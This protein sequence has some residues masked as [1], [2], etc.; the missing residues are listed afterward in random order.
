MEA[1]A[2]A[3]PRRRRPTTWP[4]SSAPSTRRTGRRSPTSTSRRPSRSSRSSSGTRATSEGTPDPE[5]RRAVPADAALGAGAVLVQGP[6]GR[7]PDDQRPGRDGRAEAGVPPGAQDRGAASSRP[8]AGTSGSASDGPQAAVLHALPRRQLD[9]DGRAVGVLEAQGRPG[10]RVRRRAGHLRRAHHGRGRAAR[11][12]CTTG[13]RWCCR[14]RRGRRG[15]TRTRRRTTRPSPRCSRLRRPELVAQPGAA[16]GVAAGQQRAQQRPRAPRARCRP[17]QVAEPLQLD[18]LAGRT[19]SDA[20]GTRSSPNPSSGTSTPR[21]GP[22]GSPCTRPRDAVAV[23]LLGHGAGGGVRRARPAR[24]PTTAALAA[25][26]HV[27]QVEQP[28]R[29]AGRRAPAPA[30]QLDAAWLAV[31]AAVRAAAARATGAR[32]RPQLGRPGGLPDG[33]GR[34]CRR[35]AVPG[36]PGAPAGPAGEGPPGRAGRADGPGA[37]RPGRARPLRSPAART[38]PRGRA[39]SR[40]TTRSRPISRESPPPSRPGS[41]PSCR[42]DADPLS[43]GA[44]TART[45]ASAPRAP[46]R[47]TV[48]RAA[49]CP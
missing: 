40:A 13:C 28:Y 2:V 37:R 14:R 33:V 5:R 4:T 49:A 17:M 21:T 24:R 25:G 10:G 47:S 42:S 19:R 46:R 41:P 6:V 18:L 32:R 34:R 39:R 1:C 29:V 30:A 44:P 8:T 7:R 22:R 26:V 38:R 3:T 20:G 36:L 35:G 45:P 31:V 27:A 15:W 9:R 11:G 12:R 48:P 23:L 43:A 16:T